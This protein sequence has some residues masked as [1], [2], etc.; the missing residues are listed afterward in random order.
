MLT[1]PTTMRRLLRP[2]EAVFRTLS[3]REM[4]RTSLIFSR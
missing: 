4:P 1:L 2:F 3:L